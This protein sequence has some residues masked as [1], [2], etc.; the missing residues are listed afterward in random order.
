MTL[1]YCGGC[2][3]HSDD[4]AVVRE[5]QD[6]VVVVAWHC[7]YHCFVSNVAVTCQSS[8]HNCKVKLKRSVPV[9]GSASL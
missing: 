7:G 4:K 2:E 9:T 6:W 5:C 1:A 3:V 8:Y